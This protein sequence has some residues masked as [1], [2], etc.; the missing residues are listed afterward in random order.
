VPDE[1][2]I[3]Q[4]ESVEIPINYE[5]PTDS[6]PYFNLSLKKHSASQ[7][8]ADLTKQIKIE[9]SRMGAY[10]QINLKD[11]EVGSY[12]L[13][14]NMTV[15]QKQ[16]IKIN[17]LQGQYWE[18]SFIL[19][20]N[21]LREFTA[22]SSTIRMETLTCK[23]AEGPADDYKLSVQLDNFSES[24]RVHLVATQLIANSTNS[25]KELMEKYCASTISSVT[26]GFAKWKNQ[27]S[28]GKDVAD[29]LLY[30]LNRKQQK[31][32]MGN[33]LDNPSLLMRRQYV[34][35]TVTADE[36]LNKGEQFD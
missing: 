17:V 18:G 11:L 10:K 27:Y 36:N 1:F 19:Q 15:S 4:G 32:K 24:S 21:K 26:F 16:F 14:L 20:N 2:N 3:I 7:V 22:P 25:L 34:R 29:E 30:V 33:L 35:N 5:G 12:V 6:I 31:P 8:L 23:K 13:K 28:D 9:P